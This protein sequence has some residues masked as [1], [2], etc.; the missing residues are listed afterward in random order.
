M[1]TPD[2]LKGI[3]DAIEPYQLGGGKHPINTTINDWPEMI[4]QLAEMHKEI[5]GQN[6][7]DKDNFNRQSF[8]Y[9]AL[10]RYHSMLKSYA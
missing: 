5:Y 7:K 2:L 9:N 4:R 3:L 6:P 8:H 1:F 10:S